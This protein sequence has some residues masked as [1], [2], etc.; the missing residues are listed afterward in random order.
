MNPD[1][2]AL[3][4]DQTAPLCGISSGSALFAIGKQS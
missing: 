2:T 1:Q 3:N 4:V